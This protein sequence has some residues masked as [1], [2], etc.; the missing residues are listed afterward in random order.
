MSPRRVAET[1]P[2]RSPRT[3]RDAS[4]QI[5]QLDPTRAGSLPELPSRPAVSLFPL[6]T[7]SPVRKPVGAVYSRDDVDVQPPVM[8]QPQ[9]PPPLMIGGPSEGTLNRMELIVASDGSVERVRLMSAPRRMADMMLLSGA[10]LWRF[11]PAVKNGEPVRYK[12]IVSWVA[13]P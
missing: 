10:K 9:L 2:S 7:A 11:A 6:A 13:F 1:P 5:A 4:A 8:L 12:T 3:P